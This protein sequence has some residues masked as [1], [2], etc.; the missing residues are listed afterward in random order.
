M[1]EIIAIIRMN[2]VN[3]TK[4]ALASEGFP[5]FNCTKAYGRGK[6]AV[7]YQLTE[8]IFLFASDIP[9]EV[10]E[11]VSEKHRLLPKRMVSITVPDE[12]AERIVK[13]I[14]EANQ[15]GNPGDG[16]IFVIP[17]EGAIRVRTGETGEAAIV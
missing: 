14:I 10:V 2:M 17:I 13:I 9:T 5:A 8:E 16:K 12:E 7:D 1:K 4:N 6:K 3:Q 11:S 15:T